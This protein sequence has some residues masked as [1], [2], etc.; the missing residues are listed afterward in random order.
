MTLGM[1]A[2]QRTEGLFGVAKRAGVE[3][4]LSLC[5]L[6]DKLQRVNKSLEVESARRV[7]HDGLEFFRFCGHRSYVVPM[8]MY[9][10]VPIYFGL[11]IYSLTAKAWCSQQLSFRVKKHRPGCSSSNT[12]S[13]P[14]YGLPT[15]RPSRLGTPT[16]AAERPFQVAHLD[17]FFGPFKEE[18]VRVGASQFCQRVSTSPCIPLCI[19]A[20]V[21]Y[22]L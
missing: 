19:A 9:E 21:E 5:A 13:I 6:W 15:P 3:K 20:A 14:N 11:P 17:K 18:L 8:S 16:I 7:S 2:T 10:A 12:M 1:A 22:A 4:K